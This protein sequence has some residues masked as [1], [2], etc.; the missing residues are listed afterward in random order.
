MV[1]GSFD[2]GP[3]EESNDIPDELRIGQVPVSCGQGAV[4]ELI[5]VSLD[6]FQQS[7]ITIP[8]QEAVCP[9]GRRRSLHA[10][11][12]QT[13]KVGDMFHICG[14]LF[15]T[16]KQTVVLQSSIAGYHHDS[17]IFGN[18]NACLIL[19]NDLYLNVK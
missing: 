17:T 3:T 19:S 4:I 10:L 11:S 8:L 9:F 2:I 1:R 7:G 13:V 12:L 6:V 18:V 14:G 16:Q 15:K 5:G